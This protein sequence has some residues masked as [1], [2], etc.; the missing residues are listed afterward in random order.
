MSI[1]NE[2]YV[3]IDF[4]DVARIHKSSCY[5]VKKWAVSRKKL[6]DGHWLPCNSV[7]DGRKIAKNA[8]CKTI[9]TC[10]KCEPR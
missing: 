2:Y 9:A 4:P 8:G 1:V 5:T 6:E 10:K 3:N 7:M